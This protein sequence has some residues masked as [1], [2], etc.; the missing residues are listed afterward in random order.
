MEGEFEQL[1]KSNSQG[2]AIDIKSEIPAGKKG[3][4]FDPVSGAIA[5][6]WIVLKVA[7]AAAQVAATKILAEMIYNKIKGKNKKERPKTVRLRFPDGTICEIEVD[8][9]K[10]QEQLQKLIAQK[11]HR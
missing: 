10:G 8:D 3:L 11:A 7:G 5:V 1:A 6:G 9:P 4:A 2:C